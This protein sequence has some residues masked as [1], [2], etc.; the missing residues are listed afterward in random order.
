MPALRELAVAVAALGIGALGLAK[1]A[2]AAKWHYEAA[3]LLYSEDGDRVRAV[4]PVFQAK[5]DFGD[6]RYLTL[7]TVVDSLTG[8]SPNGAT[9]A[10]EAQTFTSPSQLSEYRADA[11]ALPIDATFLDTRIEFSGNWDTPVGERGRGVFGW[12]VS[13]E[14]DYLSI[15][16]NALASR[17]FNRNNTTLSIGG[18]ISQDTLEPVGGTP[19]PLGNAFNVGG[20]LERDPNAPSE[21]VDPGGGFAD[22]GRALRDGDSDD[23]TVLGL[24]VGLSQVLDPNTLLR[25]NYTATRSNG[26]LSDPYKLL[27][28]IY[29]DTRPEAGQAPCRGPERLANITGLSAGD[30]V[31]YCFEARPDSRLQHNLYATLKR[32][33]SGDV[34]DFAYRFSMDDWGVDAH[35]LEARWRWRLA[36]R[37]FLRP[38]LRYYAQGAA[39][40]YRTQLVYG[41]PL[42]AELS[43][44]ARLGDMTTWTYGLELGQGESE[45]SPRHWSVAIELYTQSFDPS[46]API[47]NQ[48][49]ADLTPD[50]QA[51]MLR[52]RFGFGAR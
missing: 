29:P 7:K 15:G 20:R 11:G 18:A 51:L 36:K 1:D 31:A 49:G 8:A 41:Q 48:A 52:A 38:H 27:A 13:N 4:E 39:D 35:T 45:D 5:A 47:G 37:W 19:Y 2:E 16:A 9:P 42:D 10:A 30:P 14:Y 24:F 25:V 28:V 43:A 22:D 50:L 12:S 34:L 23:K 3:A 17:N 6:Q 44:D 33:M 32:Y 26:Y 21:P 46:G 40:F